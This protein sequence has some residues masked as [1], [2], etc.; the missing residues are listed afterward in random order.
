M[1]RNPIESTKEVVTKSTLYDIL[2]YHQQLLILFNIQCS[3]YTS[4]HSGNR[5]HRSMYNSKYTKKLQ[6]STS[7]TVRDNH[8]PLIDGRRNKGGVVGGGM[9]KTSELLVSPWTEFHQ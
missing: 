1:I 5:D 9:S 8:L 6:Q 7:R 2:H 3:C 4:T